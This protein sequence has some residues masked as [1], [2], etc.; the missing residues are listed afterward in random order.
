MTLG[1][2]EIDHFKRVNDEFLHATG[3]AVLREL[4]CLVTGH[5]REIDLVGRYGGEEFA[6]AFP[7]TDVANV[8]RLADRL[9]ELVARHDWTRVALGLSVTLSIGLAEHAGTASL[10]EQFGVAD[11]KL[12]EAKT[13]GRNRVSF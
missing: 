3:C 10:E 1:M 11:A 12:Y 6:L 9:R 8:A 4:A 13:N 2:A 7:E 5:L